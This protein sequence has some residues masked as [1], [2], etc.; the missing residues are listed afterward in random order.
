M[1][2]IISAQTHQPDPVNDE[3]LPTNQDNLEAPFPFV[4]PLHQAR[5]DKFKTNIA[6]SRR[7]NHQK[8]LSKLVKIIISFI[9]N[10]HSSLIQ[11]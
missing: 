8:H 6:Q 7:R 5:M 10:Q 9:K 2:E 3:Q 11:V 4:Q 1:K